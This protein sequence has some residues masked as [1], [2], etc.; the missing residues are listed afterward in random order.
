[1]YIYVKLGDYIHVPFPLHEHPR[2]HADI[3]GTSSMIAGAEFQRQTHRG[4]LA[5]LPEMTGLSS[6]V[7]PAQAGR[8]RR[9]VIVKI[10]S[11]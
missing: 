7:S 2:W 3:V 9:G 4:Y 10:S 6:C 1:M 11:P 8:H 5:V